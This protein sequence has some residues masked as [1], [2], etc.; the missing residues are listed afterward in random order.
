VCFQCTDFVGRI[1]W[2]V[3]GL[4]DNLFRQCTES[5][6]VMLTQCLTL[7][8]VPFRQQLPW[9]GTICRRQ[10]RLQLAA[11]IPTQT[12]S[13]Q[14]SFFTDSRVFCHYNQFILNTLCLKKTSHLWFA[15]TLTY[16]NGFIYFLFWQKCNRWSKQPKD[17]T[18]PPQITCASAL[19]GKMGKH[20]NHFSL[21]C[22]IS[23]RT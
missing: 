12:F 10:S 20:K 23:A 9:R 15:I 21:K 8:T 11:Y 1:T 17:F 5:L 16:M 13:F 22:C 3:A 4:N 14:A 18:M 6:V 19:P 2:M 7:G